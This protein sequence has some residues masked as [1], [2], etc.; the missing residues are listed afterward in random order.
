MNGEKRSTSPALIILAAGSGRRYG[1]IKQLAPVGPHGETLVEYS[2]YDAIVAGIEKIVLVIRKEQERAFRD[3]LA[4]GVAEDAE[5]EFVYQEQEV[6]VVSLG[7]RIKREKPWGTAH[8]LI[9]AQSRIASSFAVINA[10]DF[11]GRAAIRAMV[12]YLRETV[13]SHPG[14]GALVVYRLRNTLSNFGPV[15]RG[16]CQLDDDSYLSR[17]VE[18]HAIRRAGPESVIADAPDDYRILGGDELVSM[19]LWG[20][21]PEMFVRW[22]QFFQEF[23][24]LAPSVE[25]EFEIPGNVQ[26]MMGAGELRIKAIASDEHWF[27]L[28]YPDDFSEVRNRIA[29]LIEKG[30]Y[31]AR[32]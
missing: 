1:D 30:L 6:S 27:G 26:R 24:E 22:H 16:I 11:Y 21:R 25:C 12:Q 7:T 5:I 14:Y 15:N 28:T 20:L 8:A 23:L 4:R 32:L 13:A 2:I 18:C 9:T 19:N 3:K 17:I 29:A 10:D 31:P